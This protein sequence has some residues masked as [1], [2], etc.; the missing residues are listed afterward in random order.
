[1]QLNDIL[2]AMRKFNNSK[3]IA[4]TVNNEEMIVSFSQLAERV[5]ILVSILQSAGMQPGFCIG[6]SLGNCYEFLLWDLAVVQLGCVLQVFPEGY[7]PSQKEWQD[8]NIQ[9]WVHGGG[10]ALDPQLDISSPV[11][12]LS[13]CADVPAFLE[14]IEILPID[15]SHILVQQPNS[16]LHSMVYSSGT[17][18][19]LKGLSISRKGTEKLMTDFLNSFTDGARCP[20]YLSAIIQLSATLVGMGMSISGC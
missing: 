1:M 19:Y 3:L 12:D 4:T 15:K 14:S 20:S 7:Q 13:T 2:P 5:E 8:P 10:L 6:L 9:L 17:S 16:D 11:L 18:G